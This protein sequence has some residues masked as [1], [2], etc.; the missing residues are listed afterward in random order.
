M[1]VRWCFTVDLGTQEEFA[2]EEN[3]DWNPPSDP[4]EGVRYLIA[5]MEFGDEEE[6]I[7]WQGYVEMEPKKRITQIKEILECDWMHLELAR[8]NAAQNKAYIMK[9]PF[10]TVEWGAP[11]TKGARTDID[12]LKIDIEKGMEWKALCQIHT[13]ACLRYPSGVKLLKRHLQDPSGPAVMRKVRVILNWG[14]SGAGKSH[15]A[16]THDAAL[17]SKSLGVKERGWW[18]GYRSQRTLLID[19]FSGQIAI[20]E[21]KVILDIYP[22]AVSQ[23]CEGTLLFASNRKLRCPLCRARLLRAMGHGVHHEPEDHP[24]L[25]GW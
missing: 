14:V 2:V 21:M 7:H 22:Y 11:L 17:Y 24:P 12:L 5:S 13:D 1:A 8:G 10:A 15:A 4:V 23:R 20:D 19:D 6:R 9:Q 25:V 16:Y 18:E 3:K